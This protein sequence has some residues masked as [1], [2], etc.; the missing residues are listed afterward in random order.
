MSQEIL[1]VKHIRKVI[2]R[3]TSQRGIRDGKW[4]FGGKEWTFK[5]VQTIRV[6]KQVKLCQG[7]YH[8]DRHHT[9]VRWEFLAPKSFISAI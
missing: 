8:W 9:E 7:K 5:V 2:S 4:R 1:D 3:L 6:P